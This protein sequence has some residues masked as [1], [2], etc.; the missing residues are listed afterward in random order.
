MAILVRCSCGKSFSVKDEYAGKRGRCPSCQKVVTVPAADDEAEIP[1]APSPIPTRPSV[2]AASAT[3]APAMDAAGD[4]PH[5]TAARGG[6]RFDPVAAAGRK[7]QATPNAPRF[8]FSPRAITFIALLI[9][10]PLVI[11]IVKAGPVSAFDEYQ[12]LEPQ[13]EMW[14][15]DALQKVLNEEFKGVVFEGVVRPP[16]VT[17]I[18]IDS[19]IMMWSLP[20]EV[21]VQGE[22]SEGKFKG[23]Y[24]TQ[25]KRLK[26]DMGLEYDSRKVQVD[27]HVDGGTLVLDGYK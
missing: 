11:A 24:Y 2:A 16:K 15:N 23:H 8:A 21:F 12:K 27:A 4:R 6:T 5:I 22:T 7:A 10:I 20:D 14:T 3:P 17:N 25:T 1:L 13:I 19:P 9:G 18:M 26:L